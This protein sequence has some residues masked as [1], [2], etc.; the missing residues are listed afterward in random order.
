MEYLRDNEADL[1]S[2]FT[3]INRSYDE[4]TKKGKRSLIYRGKYK[5][6]SGMFI[7]EIDDSTSEIINV[8]KI[9]G[10]EGEKEILFEK[11]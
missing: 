5:E 9:L 3:S 1:F 4:V 10:K 8:V 6:K 2:S 11:K 7:I